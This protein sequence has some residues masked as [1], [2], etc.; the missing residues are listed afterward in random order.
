M[1]IRWSPGCACCEKPPDIVPPPTCVCGVCQFYDY[2]SITQLT[3]WEFEPNGTWQDCLAGVGQFDPPPDTPWAGTPVNECVLY[4][5]IDFGRG[6]TWIRYEAGGFIQQDVGVGIEEYT[7]ETLYS[8][9]ESEEQCKTGGKLVWTFNAGNPNP[10]TPADGGSITKDAF[11]CRCLLNQAGGGCN[12]N[13]D[14]TDPGSAAVIFSNI[15]LW[16]WAENADP[17]TKLQYGWQVGPAEYEPNPGSDPDLVDTVRVP[18]SNTESGPLD[19]YFLFSP[20]RTDVKG[21]YFRGWGGGTD[22]EFEMDSCSGSVTATANNG[23]GF[24]LSVEFD[25]VGYD[26]EFQ[27]AP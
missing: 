20:S 23:Q 21:K 18:F 24:I 8:E 7:I 12:Y 26:C 9:K 1:P 4:L 13:R 11:W 15:G 5:P 16:Y 27:G 17:S 3:L 6:V 14:E 10:P 22:E 25:F 19:Y 2:Q